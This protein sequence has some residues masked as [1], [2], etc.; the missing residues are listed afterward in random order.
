MH[1]PVTSWHNEHMR[2][3]RLLDF[4]DTQVV[5]FH[6]GGQPDYELMRD[7]LHYLQHF[8]DQYH[9]PYEDETFS[10]LLERA[11]DMQLV[12]SRL[13]QEHRVIA[14]AGNRLLKCVEY[15]LQDNVIERAEVEAA[16]ATYLV[17]YRHHL[18]TEERSV[19][20]VAALM[21]RAEDWE[22][23]AEKT[24]FAP[25]PLFGDQIEMRYRRLHEHIHRSG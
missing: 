24:R 5:S 14:V 7:V 22:A 2:F 19:L 18:D 11:P 10:W 12:I 23:I 9:H 21:L 25:D 6:A 20:P 16:A 1:N 8:A 4:L 17:Y 3:A 15:I 13:L